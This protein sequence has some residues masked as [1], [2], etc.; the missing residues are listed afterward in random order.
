M[1]RFGV[2]QNDFGV[3]MKASFCEFRK[4]KIYVLYLFRA[5]YLMY[6]DSVGNAKVK[7]HLLGRFLCDRNR[8]FP[9]GKQISKMRRCVLAELVK[10][11]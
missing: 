8:A 2:L 4:K 3:C 9:G 7:S 6:F 10:S 11:L 1:I 5:L